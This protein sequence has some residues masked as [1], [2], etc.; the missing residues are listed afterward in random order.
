MC[1]YWPLIAFIVTKIRAIFL[2]IVDNF[3]FYTLYYIMRSFCN[4]VD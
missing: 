4:F 3:C 1:D 2:L